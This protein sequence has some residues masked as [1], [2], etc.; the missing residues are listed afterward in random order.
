MTR[1]KRQ[2]P[3]GPNRPIGGVAAPPLTTLDEFSDQSVG[4]WLRAAANLQSLHAALHFGLEAQRGRVSADLTSA[5]LAGASRSLSVEGWSRIVD[6]RYGLVP[7]SARGSLSGDGGR[8]NIGANLNPSSFTAF[9]ALYIG[10]DYETA[11]AEKFGRMS[12]DETDGLS[13]LE[14]A[15][16]RTKSFTHVLLRGQID[17]VLDVGNDDALTPFVKVIRKFHVPLEAMQKARQMGVKPPSIVRSVEILRTTLTDPYWLRAPMQFDLP[18]N[19]QVFG[20]IVAAAGIHGILYPSA[21]LPGKQ[22]L[23]LFPQNWA[24]SDSYVEVAD[25]VPDHARLS[26]VAADTPFLD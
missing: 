21:R 26:R 19:S 9:P 25:A 11:F 3:N 23:A 8:F 2:P 13:P 16:R 20:R 24:G 17:I 12:T 5:L 10:E 6:Y 4:A 22:C 7:L 14:L 18:A 15:L 1:R